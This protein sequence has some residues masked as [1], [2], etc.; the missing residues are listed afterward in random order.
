M[1]QFANLRTLDLSH[2][3]IS[4]L[5]NTTLQGLVNLEEL[6]LS[7]NKFPTIT[8]IRPNESFAHLPKLKRLRLVNNTLRTFGGQDSFRFASSSLEELD[9]S[10][11]SIW[12][13]ADRFLFSKLGNLRLLNAS[14]NPLAWVMDLSSSTLTTLDVSHANLDSISTNAVVGLK[15]LHT[16][17]MGYND[18]LRYY[19]VRVS[20]R[21]IFD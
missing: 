17:H 8:A 13:I 20:S 5:D 10:A 21:F 7:F 9:I 3:R 2:N 4:S 6:D 15:S 16:L 11:C 12:N 14:H 19:K 1:K 18:K